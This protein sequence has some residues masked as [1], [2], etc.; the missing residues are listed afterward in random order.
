LVRGQG[1]FEK[2]FKFQFFSQPGN[3]RGVLLVRELASSIMGLGSMLGS[4]RLSQ[5]VAENLPDPRIARVLFHQLRKIWK[6]LVKQSLALN[7]VFVGMQRPGQVT[8][9]YASPCGKQ[10]W[11]LPSVDIVCSIDIEFATCSSPGTI[12]GSSRDRNG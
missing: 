5:R 11:I 3:F 9:R 2:L 7:Q 4:A 8:L 1:F 10:N 12:K 6:D